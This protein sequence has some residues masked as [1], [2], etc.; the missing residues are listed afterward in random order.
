MSRTIALFVT[1]RTRLEESNTE[2]RKI[3]NRDQLT[4]LATLEAFKSVF[5]NVIPEI[6]EEKVKALCYFDINN[7][8]YINENYGHQ[9]GDKVLKFLAQDI[10]EQDYFVMASRLYSDFFLFL[11]VGDDKEELQRKITTQQK[12]FTNM[13]NH[14]Y[15]NSGMGVTAGVYVIEDA[16]MDIEQA[17]ERAGTKAGNKGYDVA[18]TA[19]EMVNLMKNF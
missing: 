10:A 11:A 15:P 14:Q 7:F 13:Q 18:C 16:R 2:I 8:G 17:I 4:G 19:I 1:L 9:V 5:T 12:K 6:P 3:Q